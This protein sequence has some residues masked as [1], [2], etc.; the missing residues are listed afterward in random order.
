MGAPQSRHKVLASLATLKRLA[1]EL[2]ETYLDGD[3]GL[4]DVLM[5]LKISSDRIVRRG[6]GAAGGVEGPSSSKG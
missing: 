4:R 5:E 3:L 1:S 6:A 2:M